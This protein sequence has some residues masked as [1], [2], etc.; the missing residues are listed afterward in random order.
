[1]VTSLFPLPLSSQSL[2][3]S[4][5]VSSLL[6]HLPLELGS[7]PNN[8]GQPHLRILNY[9]TESSQ[10]T[11]QSQGPFSQNTDMFV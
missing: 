3:L 6:G 8:P 1:M 5:P 7:P 9:I 2:Q 4:I 10:I 11:S